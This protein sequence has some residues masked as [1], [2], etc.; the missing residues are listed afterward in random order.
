MTT[1]LEL[2]NIKCSGCANTLM[3]ALH[4]YKEVQDPF[5]DAAGGKVSFSHPDGFRLSGLKR[6]LRNLGYPVK[7]SVKGL[8][9]AAVAALS[10]ASCA[11]GKLSN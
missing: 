2:E 6:K 5:V 4:S 3:K 10:Y 8:E 7:G 9:K 11:V 1:T